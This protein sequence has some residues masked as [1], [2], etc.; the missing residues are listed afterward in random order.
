MVMKYD[1]IGN[2]P[3]LQGPKI[4]NGLTKLGNMTPIPT[5]MTPFQFHFAH[6]L[7]KNDFVTN[8]S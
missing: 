7:L 3:T 8:N 1:K 6:I 4:A 2:L 5:R